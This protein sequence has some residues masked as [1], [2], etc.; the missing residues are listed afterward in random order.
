M[1]TFDTETSSTNYD[2]L[3]GGDVPVNTDSVTIGLA[4]TLTRGAALGKQTLGDGSVVDGTNTGDGTVTLLAGAGGDVVPTVGDYVLTCTATG[5]TGTAAGDV[6]DGTNTG[7][8]TVTGFA[9]SSGGTPVVGDWVLTCTD[10]N[11]GGTGSGSFDYVGTGNGT[12]GAGAIGPELI[13][14]DYVLTCY[15]ASVSGSEIFRV[16]DPNGVILEDLTVGVAYSNSHF[17]VTISD[18]STDFTAGGVWTLTAMIAH[19]GVFKLVDPNGVTVSSD[20]T[21][22]GTTGGTVVP[23]V[24]GITFTITDGA[25]DFAADDS[26]TLTVTA[27]ES[28]GGVFKLVDPDGEMVASGLA[29]AAG[30]GVVTAFE[31]AGMTFSITDGSTDFVVGDSFTL[32]FAAGTGYAIALDKDALDGSQ[33]IYGICLDA[34][35]T[36]ASTDTATVAV[37][38]SFNSDNVTFV[39]GT[40]YTDVEADARTKGIFFVDGVY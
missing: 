10:A 12:A 32:T 25:T 18:G 22:P 2:G 6:V 31:V 15:D 38:G 1:A 28:G 39:S 16:V 23:D 4:Q 40:A 20:I 11:T 5:G 13:E 7:D 37:T 30:A 27:T 24:G 17:G 14:G 35:T 9:I 26:F 21:L 33:L 29:M 34:V 19:G 3:I 8:G 36:V